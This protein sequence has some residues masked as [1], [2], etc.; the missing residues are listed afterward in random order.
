MVY[1]SI[2]YGSKRI[3]LAL[4]EDESKLAQ[5]L[6][7]LDA[8]D[9]NLLGRLVK[10]IRQHNVNELVVGLPRNLDGEE[11]AQTAVVRKFA[12]KLASLGFPIHLQDEAGTS[13]LARE[14]I[15][16][17]LKDKSQID[18]EAA[19]IILQDFLD[20]LGSDKTDP[21]PE[22]EENPEPVESSELIV[23]EIQWDDPDDTGTQVQNSPEQPEGSN[24]GF[25]W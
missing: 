2:D 6:V 4:G 24:N 8:T 13:E 7:T 10:L 3:G 17:K 18:A 23:E 11:T 15:G 1:L 19:A 22:H 5:P 9:L 12:K 25:D 21:T 20:G 16:K 14:R